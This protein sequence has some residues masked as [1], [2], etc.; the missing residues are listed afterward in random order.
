MYIKSLLLTSLSSQSFSHVS[1]QQNLSLLRTNRRIDPK[2]TSLALIHI[3]EA[4]RSVIAGGGSDKGRGQPHTEALCTLTRSDS[5]SRPAQKQKGR[6]DRP[7][8]AR[9]CWLRGRHVTLN[10]QRRIPAVGSICNGAY[11]AQAVSSQ[12]CLSPFQNKTK[13]KKQQNLF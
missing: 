1:T 6:P 8:M 5:I 2:V 13:K 12:Q 11:V 3:L 10:S 4:R 9:M 7:T